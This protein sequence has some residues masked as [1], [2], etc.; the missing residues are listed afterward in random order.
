MTR[1]DSAPLAVSRMIA[2]RRSGRSR[3]RRITSRPS[4]P[5]SIR[6]STIRSGE[7]SETASS[8]ANPSRATRVE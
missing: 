2:L 4:R 1:S 6:S 7:L 3:T 5:G 8:A